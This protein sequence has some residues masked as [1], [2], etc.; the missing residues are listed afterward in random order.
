MRNFC[1]HC[2]SL[3]TLLILLLT[4]IGILI[5]ILEYGSDAC[6]GISSHDQFSH[7]AEFANHDAG[8]A[9]GGRQGD[10][11]C[12][13][14]DSW[15]EEGGSAALLFSLDGGGGFRIIE[16]TVRVG[17]TADCT[18]W[19]GMWDGRVDGGFWLVGG[20]LGVVVVVFVVVTV[21]ILFLESIERKSTAKS[22]LETAAAT[23]ARCWFWGGFEE[24]SE[25]AVI[26]RHALFWGIEYAAL[27]EGRGTGE[28]VRISGRRRRSSRPSRGRGIAIRRTL[29][30]GGVPGARDRTLVAG[31][32]G[33]WAGRREDLGGGRG[34]RA[35][36][37]VVV[38]SIWA[39]IR[40]IKIL[41]WRLV[42]GEH[43]LPVRPLRRTI[44][45]SH[46]RVERC[47]TDRRCPALPTV[48]SRCCPMLMV[49]PDLAVVRRIVCCRW[50]LARRARV[51]LEDSSHR[52]RHKLSFQH[53][54][55]L[56]TTPLL[57]PKLAKN[58]IIL[59]TRILLKQQTQMFHDLGILSV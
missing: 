30:R 45:V 54:L 56:P 32:P 14:I 44:H 53:L 59:L 35:R 33:A 50:A 43:H 17:R 55:I 58:F 38:R 23:D 12:A 10:I 28:P 48:P 34:V 22:A 18:C 20:S 42:C 11:V 7:R 26:A 51:H 25:V 1:L 5:L 57:L 15:V 19:L 49:L 16:S 41:L 4:L 6:E 47:R 39:S 8:T 36:L 46:P 3:G 2:A 24:G 21:I 37:V 27:G 13:G 29:R 9:D 31:R 52:P 40:M